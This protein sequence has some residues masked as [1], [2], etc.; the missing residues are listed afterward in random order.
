MV[1]FMPDISRVHILDHTLYGNQGRGYRVLFWVNCQIFLKSYGTLE[2]FVNIGPYRA[3]KFQNATP[4]T[5]YIRIR[6][7]Q[8]I[9][10]ALLTIVKYRLIHFIGNW[11]SFKILWHFSVWDHSVHFEIL[12]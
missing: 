11:R 2:F 8:S 7:Q 1:F 5:V 3:T 12:T 9:T 10:R 4:H 6:Y